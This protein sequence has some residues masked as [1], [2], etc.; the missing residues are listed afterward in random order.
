MV[1]Q[2]LVQAV[3]EVQVHLEAQVAQV[4]MARMVARC[5]LLLLRPR[6]HGVHRKSKE[7]AI[8][9]D[10][11]RAVHCECRLAVCVVVVDG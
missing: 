1:L 2:G 3:P 5:M 7:A 4:V 11:R 10:V 9:G 6:L 8:M